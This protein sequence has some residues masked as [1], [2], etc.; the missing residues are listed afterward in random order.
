MDSAK[1]F[2]ALPNELLTQILSYAGALDNEPPTAS[3]YKADVNRLEF[4]STLEHPWRKFSQVSKRWKE[5]VLPMLVKSS[6]ISLDT[7]LRGHARVSTAL[8]LLLKNQPH[9][10]GFIQGALDDHD[11]A[12]KTTVGYLEDDLIELDMSFQRSLHQRENWLLWIIFLHHKVEAFLHFIVCHGLQ[13]YVKG[14]TVQSNS[15]LYRNPNSGESLLKKEVQLMW[16]RLFKV[17]KPTRLTVIATPFRMMDLAN[18]KV[19]TLDTW[20]FNTPYHF[21]ELRLDTDK[22]TE[23]ETRTREKLEGRLENGLLDLYQRRPWTHMIY[24]EGTM[25]SGYSC[26][27]WQEKIPPRNLPN[28]LENIILG[29]RFSKSPKLRSFSYISY[30]PY[31]E[32]VKAVAK[33]L[34]KLKDL[35]RIEVSL[36]NVDIISDPEKLGKGQIADCWLEWELSYKTIIEELLNNGGAGLVFES[37]DR[38]TTTLKTNVITEMESLAPYMRREGTHL[39]WIKT[40]VTASTAP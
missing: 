36:A 4:V 38:Q 10:K 37:H 27:E 7:I 5:I 6:C 29:H 21:L 20:A 15:S 35:K 19:E 32:H 34:S 23:S 11:D 8:M 18:N 22:E 40:E 30:F 24:N 1:G 2:D 31:S 16:K 13:K 12:Q 33:S 26:Y 14:L 9:L 39:R 17:I 25:I 28:L 3:T